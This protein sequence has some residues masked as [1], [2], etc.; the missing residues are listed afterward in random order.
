MSVFGMHEIASNPSL[1]RL[2]PVRERLLTEVEFYRNSYMAI[3]KQKYA[4]EI[5]K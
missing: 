4:V 2:V 3:L 1:A 5:I